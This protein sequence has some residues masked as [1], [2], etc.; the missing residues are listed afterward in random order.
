MRLFRPELIVRSLSLIKYSGIISKFKNNGFHKVKLPTVINL[1]LNVELI[2]IYV[3]SNL[4]M[5]KQR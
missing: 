1:N 5:S 4:E 2:C 3:I